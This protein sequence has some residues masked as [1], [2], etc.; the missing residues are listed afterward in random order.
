MGEL[1][2]GDDAYSLG[3]EL[4]DQFICQFDHI[5]LSMFPLGV[6]TSKSGRDVRED[7]MNTNCIIENTVGLRRDDLVDEFVSESLAKVGSDPQKLD[8][9]RVGEDMWS[10]WSDAATCPDKHHPPEQACD[11]HNTECGLSVACGV[12]RMSR[13]IC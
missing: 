1:G 7:V 12:R 3:V 5:R 6:G 13:G 4:L 9:G 8:G 2:V 11:S 10:E